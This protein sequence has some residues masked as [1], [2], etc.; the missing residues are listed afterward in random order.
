MRHKAWTED[1]QPTRDFTDA[2]V[3]QF[4]RGAMCL[5]MP[6]QVQL[7]RIETPKQNERWAPVRGH[8]LLAISGLT[9]CRRHVSIAK[10]GLTVATLCD[11]SA[12]FLR[13]A[14][15]L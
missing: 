15:V 11:A 5:P 1:Q 7:S 14:H 6:I 2:N 8:S 9:Q 10:G 13:H 3:Y 12:D 4:Q